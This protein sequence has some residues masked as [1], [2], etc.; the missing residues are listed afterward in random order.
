MGFMNA[1]AQARLLSAG[2][3]N[4]VLSPTCA[5]CSISPARAVHW[6]AKV[7]G[8]C[9]TDRPSAPKASRPRPWASWPRPGQE[10][11]QVLITN[12]AHT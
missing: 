4:V 7:R 3:E 2:L 1:E 6:A 12:N 11:G 9:G 8:R 10:T 5:T